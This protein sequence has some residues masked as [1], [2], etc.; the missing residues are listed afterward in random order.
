MESYQE[1]SNLWDSEMDGFTGLLGARVIGDFDSFFE[2]IDIGKW[3]FM[4]R[5]STFKNRATGERIR[6]REWLRLR[7]AFVDALYPL[8]IRVCESMFDREI[9]LHEWV[10]QM[11]LILKQGHCAGWMFGSGG[12][13]TIIQSSIITLEQTLREQYEFLT[14]FAQQIY[15]GYRFS[16]EPEIQ[17]FGSQ[18]QHISLYT[19]RA[20]RRQGIINRSTLYV[21]SVTQ[22]AERGRATS[23]RLL[24][25]ELPEYPG[26]GNQI[27]RTRCRCHWRFQFFKPE[28]GFFHA[29]WRLNPR[30]KH[31][32]TC[33]GN[34]ARW[35][36]LSIAR[37]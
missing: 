24:A 34:A 1:G 2:P 15:D 14:A 10:N 27:C 11:A 28:P 7:D 5:T 9:T 3:N 23:Y 18:R 19:P 36:P 4:T 30:A 32:A 25:D 17:E 16:D 6:D 35:N 22:S 20:L 37:F 31:C 13:N 12:Y 33:L 29:F 26:D 8:V 21:E